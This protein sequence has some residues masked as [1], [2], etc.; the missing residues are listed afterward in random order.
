[1]IKYQFQSFQS[2]RGHHFAVYHLL[3]NLVRVTFQR[4]N[5]IFKFVGN[6][7]SHFNH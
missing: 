4:K 2:T 6:L 3:S 5:V 7:N 1:M